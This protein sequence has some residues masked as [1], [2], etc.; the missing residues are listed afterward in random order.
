METVDNKYYNEPEEIMDKAISNFKEKAKKFNRLK[1]FDIIITIYELYLFV[2]NFSQGNFLLAGIFFC[3]TLLFVFFTYKDIK[4][5]KIQ[6][7]AAEYLEKLKTNVEA[8]VELMTQ[9]GI[10]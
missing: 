10:N 9:P 6:L 3:L 7:Q 8:F 1:Y 5:K 2:R 4:M